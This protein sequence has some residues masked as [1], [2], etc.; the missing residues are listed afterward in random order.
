MVNQRQEK[1]CCKNSYVSYSYGAIE[2]KD[3]DPLDLLMIRFMRNGRI[4]HTNKNNKNI[5]KY[6]ISSHTAVL[7]LVHVVY[8]NK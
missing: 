6:T 4:H 5:Y 3:K 2:P 1:D 8:E 7:L